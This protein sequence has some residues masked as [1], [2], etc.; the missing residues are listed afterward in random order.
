MKL[1]IKLFVA[2]IIA[3]IF[4]WLAH[5]LLF[6]I[7]VSANLDFLI[8][9]SKTDYLIYSLLAA[10]LFGLSVPIFLIIKY[11]FTLSNL[12]IVL[13]VI[14]VFIIFNLIFIH[15]FMMFGDGKLSKYYIYNMVV[16]ELVG[17]VVYIKVLILWKKIEEKLGGDI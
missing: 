9:Y 15:D 10:F 1:L 17:I 13:G 2:S 6:A 12:N 5:I 14:S 7:E 8:E 3:V 11:F 16:I 4:M